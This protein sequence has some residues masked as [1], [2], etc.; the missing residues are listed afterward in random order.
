MGD[1]SAHSESGEAKAPREDATSEAPGDGGGGWRPGGVWVRAG[2]G[3]GGPNIMY[4]SFVLFLFL[5][6]SGYGEK[7]IGQPRYNAH[8]VGDGIWTVCL[9]AE[10]WAR[11]P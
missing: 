9:K 1:R 10:K 7:E 11:C 5:L 3:P 8:V 2:G 6:S 4:F